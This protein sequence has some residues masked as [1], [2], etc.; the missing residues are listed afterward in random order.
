MQKQSYRSLNHSCTLHA[1]FLD[2]LKNVCHLFSLEP[3][4]TRHQ[5]TE[6]STA[7]NTI[8]KETIIKIKNVSAHKSKL[9]CSG[10]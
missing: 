5:S 1:H 10:Q 7:T 3:L 4:Q 9:T 6:C 8:T 2:G